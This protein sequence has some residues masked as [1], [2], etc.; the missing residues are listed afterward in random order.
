MRG[1]GCSARYIL[2]TMRVSVL[3]TSLVARICPMTAVGSSQGWRSRSRRLFG[4]DDPIALF[5]LSAIKGG[6]GGPQQGIAGGAMFWK[7]GDPERQ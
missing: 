6:V 5:A 4:Y 3:A 2:M 7:I 1:R